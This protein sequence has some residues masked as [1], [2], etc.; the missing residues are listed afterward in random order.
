[1][2]KLKI[3][4]VPTLI[5]Y[6]LLSNWNQSFAATH[7]SEKKGDYPLPL[8][9]GTITLARA[10]QVGHDGHDLHLYHN[11]RNAATLEDDPQ[12]QKITGSCLEYGI[13]ILAAENGEVLIAN[14]TGEH[15]GMGTSVVMKGQDEAQLIYMHMIENSLVVEKGEQIKA[16]QIIGLMGS[17]GHSMGNTCTLH[18]ENPLTGKAEAVTVS[19][20]HLH[21]E[22]RTINKK[23]EKF[24]HLINSFVGQEIY[25]NVPKQTSYISTTKMYD[26]KGYW[27]QFGYRYDYVLPEGGMDYSGTWNPALMPNLANGNNPANPLL[28]KIKNLTPLYPTENE[29][30]TYTITG[31]RLPDN[32]E[33]EFNACNEIKW[34]E[35]TTEK[36]QFKCLIDTPGITGGKITAPNIQSNDKKPITMGFDVKVLVRGEKQGKPVYSGYPKLP[37]SIEA[38]DKIE[39]SVIGKN[40]PED[41]TFEIPFC[42]EVQYSFFGVQRQSLRCQLGTM[43]Y[44]T[45]GKIK[46]ELLTHD[47]QVKNK[48][49]EIVSQ[50]SVV[51][52]HRIQIESITPSVAYFGQKTSFTIK[53]KGVEKLSTFHLDYC[54]NLIVL[55]SSNLKDQVVIQCILPVP[56]SFFSSLMPDSLKRKTLNLHIKDKPGGEMILAGKIEAIAFPET[57]VEKLDPA[58]PNLG[59]KTTFILHGKHLPDKLLYWI[60]NCSQGEL[61]TST[62][63]TASFNCTPEP[64]GTNALKNI[65]I[66]A[67]KAEEDPARF[68]KEIEKQRRVIEIKYPREYSQD[69]KTAITIYRENILPLPKAYRDLYFSTLEKLTGTKVP[70]AFWLDEENEVDVIN[71][72][73]KNQGDYSNTFLKKFGWKNK[74]SNSNPLYEL[75]NCSDELKKSAKTYGPRQRHSSKLNTTGSC[76]TGLN[77]ELIE[78]ELEK[79]YP[80]KDEPPKK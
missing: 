49:G 52:D 76:A 47:I 22:I 14:Q 17:T 29:E 7:A 8:P 39:L 34:L 10:L 73:L 75:M 5:I 67:A 15:G 13:P 16:G 27:N 26:P 30:T 2:N 64:T 40:L 55:S 48:E 65:Q 58:Y 72:I 35:R 54:Q 69:G 42:Q 21:F 56:E 4:L 51:I 70:N 38:G 6:L 9:M 25:D 36:Q 41:L 45:N 31:E 24:A 53:G 66:A 32:L 74:G 12:K 46:N 50:G 62:S 3:L 59:E 18:K 20:V 1:M 71:Y 28:P 68:I 19:G 80:D 77:I 61:K 78:K 63:Q 60:G 44:D 43:N 33:V 37:S 79:M 23:G 57:W 11:K